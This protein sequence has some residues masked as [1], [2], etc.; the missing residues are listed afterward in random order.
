M[1]LIGIKASTASR[2]TRVKKSTASSISGIAVTGR[3]LEKADEGSQK[4][5]EVGRGI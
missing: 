5:L 3:F 4:V 1:V 2:R